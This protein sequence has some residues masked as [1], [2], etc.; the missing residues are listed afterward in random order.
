MRNIIRMVALVVAGWTGSASAALMSPIGVDGTDWL[1]PV[2]FVGYSWNDLASVCDPTT[3]ICIGSLGAE[4][5][6]GWTWASVDDVNALFNFYLGSNI[7]GPGPEDYGEVDSSWAPAF[8]A[9]GWLTTANNGR[10]YGWTRTSSCCLPSG[11]MVSLLQ[12][13]QAT[14]GVDKAYTQGSALKN[15]NSLDFG[16]FF[17]RSS[18]VQPPSGVPIPPTLGLLGLALAGLGWTRRSRGTERSFWRFHPFEVRSNDS[19]VF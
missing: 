16:G 11:A 9:D 10:M 2:D 4:D 19:V 17:Y 3:G 12:D 5:L 8:F 13:W 7:L 1:Q 15:T 6:T 14:G 18:E